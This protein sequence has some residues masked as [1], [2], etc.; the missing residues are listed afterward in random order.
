MGPGHAPA[1]SHT[2]LVSTAELRSRVPQV[3]D[4]SQVTLQIWVVVAQNTWPHV[5]EAVHCTSHLSALQLTELPHAL[6]PAH[7]TVQ[8][9]PAH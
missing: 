3:C 4:R 7:S 9:L 1:P 5:P 2:I 8:A 6:T